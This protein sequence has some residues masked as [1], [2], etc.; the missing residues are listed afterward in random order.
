MKYFMFLLIIITALSCNRKDP[1]EEFYF[2][3]EYKAYI[4]FPTGSYWVYSDTTFNVTDS[5]NLQYQNVTLN[6]YCDTRT[7]FEEILEQRY[8]SSFFYDG[9]PYL[10]VWGHAS[11]QYY[12]QEQDHPMG[13]FTDNANFY[14]TMTV[15]N[16]LYHDVRAVQFSQGTAEFYWAKNIGLIKKVMPYDYQSDSVVNFELV[17]YHI[18][19]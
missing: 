16:V 15:N 8:F 1:C 11:H 14:D 7:E 2:S 13:V 10:S 9:S 3:N 12:N 6:D 17:R 5:V 4:F 19:N 18:N